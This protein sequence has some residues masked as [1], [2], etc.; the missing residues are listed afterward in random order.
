MSSPQQP[1]ARRSGKGAAT[2]QDSRE[3]QADE[4]GTA[5]ARKGRPHGTDR[6]HKG[7]GKGGGTPPEQQPGH[8]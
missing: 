3:M 8:P 4:A 5:A 1:E 2:P 7:G 6:G